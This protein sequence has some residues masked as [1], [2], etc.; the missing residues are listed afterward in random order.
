[1]LRMKPV[2]KGERGARRAELYYEKTDAGYYQGG[3]GLHAEWGGKD[4]A[5]LGLEGPPDY[6]HFKRLVRG[7]DPHT[8][9][10][11]TARLRDDRVPGWDVTGCVPKGVTAA[12]ERGDERISPA[13]WRA[14]RLALDRVEH[15]ATTRVRIDGQ[16][17][18]RVTGNMLYYAVEHADTRPVED[19]ALP[20]DHPWRVM[21]LPDRHIHAFIP[22]LTWDGVEDRW[23]ALKFRPIMDLRKFFDRS[24]DAMLAAELADLGYEIETKWKEDRKGNRKYYSWDIKDMPAP[25]LARLSKRSEEIDRLEQEIVAERK[26][27]DPYA[28]DSLSQVEKDQLGAT[29]RRQKRDDLT[30]AECRQYWDTLFTADDRSGIAATIERAKLGLNPRPEKLAAKAAA[31]AMRHHFEQASAVPVEELVIT[32]LEHSIGSSRPEDIE[33]ELKRLGVILVDRDGRKLATTE[34]LMWEEEALAAWAADGRGMAAPIGVAEGLSREL[35]GGKRLNDGQWEAARGLLASA[36]RVNVIEGPAGAGKSSLLKKFDEGV[37]RAGKHATY[38]GTTSTSV[39]VLR[40]D[41]FDDTQTVARFLLDDKMKQ[42]ARGGRVVVDETSMLGH[43]DAARLIAVAKQY[44]L[45][46]IFVGDPM[47][48]GSV[49]RGSFLRLLTQYGH[50]KPFQLREI[51]RQEN[52]DYRAAAQLLS[53]GKAAEGFDALDK[54]EWIKEMTHGGDRYTHMAADYVQARRDGLAWNDVLMVA[55]T[56]RES[57]YITQ[58]IRSQLR[59]AS[60][61]ASDERE[62]T[63]L[64]QVEAS[65]AER[66]L[67]STYRPGDVIQFHQNA[68]GGFTKGQRLVVGNPAEVP[69]GQADKF[70]VY[71]TEKIGL[72]AGDVIRFTG[73]VRTLGTDHA[74]KNGDAH[75]IAGFTDGGNIRLDNGWV[76]S[77]KDAGHFRHGFVETSM[78]SQG[79]T[80]RRAILGMSAAAGRVAINMQQLYVSSSRA[81]ESVRI[82]TDD[83]AAIREDIQKDSRKLLALDLKAALPEKERRRR[84]EEEERHRRVYDRMVAGWR[85]IAGS[86]P[87]TPPRHTPP[88]P[89][90]AARVRAGQQQPQGPRL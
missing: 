83:K 23:K 12:A 49:A 18:D 26:K 1:M 51:L 64:V 88:A 41:G 53:E 30:L 76:I 63:R 3:S 73:G 14:M 78:G 59:E 74:I 75:A 15:Y 86:R 72:A 34:S 62:F 40:K 22:N 17:E 10:Q 50:I 61:L 38:L 24:F 7:L 69:V 56:H 57:G 52:P 37:K 55:P 42:A 58:A 82:Y 65:E 6:E 35:G 46:L 29:S 67:A 81:K 45:K 21:P 85:R 36:N 43:K 11:L 71:R 9:E 48:H 25:A 39:K 70:A 79:R 13:I 8:G 16:Q 32:A 60:Q 19:E 28:P 47:Q 77:G 80:V 2:G 66:G 84:A 87:P 27:L 5:R 89:T 31:F 44:D 90:H 68:K 4:A 54:L 20:E 33:R